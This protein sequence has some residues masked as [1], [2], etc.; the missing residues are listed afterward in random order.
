MKL[1]RL[2]NSIVNMEHVLAVRDVGEF[3]TVVFAGSSRADPL[4]ITIRNDDCDALRS[5]LQRCGVNDLATEH[6]CWGWE[7]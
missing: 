2:G 3:M 7:L 1:V 5:W 4:T 6:A